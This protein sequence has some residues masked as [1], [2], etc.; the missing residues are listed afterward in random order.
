LGGEHLKLGFT[1]EGMQATLTHEGFANVEALRRSDKF[2]HKMGWLRDQSFFQPEP[3]GPNELTGYELCLLAKMFVVAQGK[4]DYSVAELAYVQGDIRANKVNVFISHY[5][6]ELISETFSAMQSFDL[7][8]QGSGNTYYFLD[9]F[10]IRQASENDFDL[11]HVQSL[12]KGVDKTMLV[13]QP[14]REPDAITR[15][16][17][18]FEILVTVESSV[19]LEVSMVHTRE[20]AVELTGQGHHKAIFDCIIDGLK[21]INVEKAEARNLEDR[22]KIMSAI[23]SGPGFLRT[24]VV[25]AAAVAK[26]IGQEL[27]RLSQ[28]RSD[29]DELLPLVTGEDEHIIVHL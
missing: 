19:E 23:A 12:I 16:W 11:D 26:A 5:Q 21:S 17:C 14:W 2:N 10:S 7:R 24:N 3:N 4:G 6:A 15:V 8:N 25:V 1:L 22:E 20:L 28:R 27:E 29:E 9:V 18:V 13:A